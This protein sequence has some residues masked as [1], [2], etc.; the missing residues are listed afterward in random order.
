MSSPW[1]HA[2]N[3]SPPCDTFALAR[4]RAREI[5]AQFGDDPEFRR[6]EQAV[7]VWQTNWEICR[8]LYAAAE[9]LLREYPV[10][11]DA[12]TLLRAVALAAPRATHLYR[13]TWLNLTAWEVLAEYAVGAQLNLPLASFTSEFKQAC[14][15]AWLARDDEDGTEIVIC[16][17]PGARAVRID[18]LAPDEI[19]WR[20][21]EWI[22][23]G[24]FLITANEYLPEEHRV[25]LTVVQEGAFDVR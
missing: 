20:E 17:E 8:Q 23:G 16:L 21:R 25:E 1:L 10:Q 9:A 19:H 18:L 5:R 7:A 13:G 14:E 4:R 2:L 6:F 11:G 12:R 24:R 3:S 22:S 15:F